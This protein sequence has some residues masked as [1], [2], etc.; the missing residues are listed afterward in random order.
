MDTVGKLFRSRDIYDLPKTDALFASAMRETCSFCYRNCD[1]YKRILDRKGFAPEMIDS[2]EDLSD[3]PFIPTLYFKHHHLKSVPDRK[4]FISATSSG[5]SGTMSNIVFDL[6]SLLTGAWMVLNVGRYHK[7]WSVVPVNYIIFGYQPSKTNRTAISKTA[8]GFTFFAPAISRTF[9][10]EMT[11]SGY[12]LNWDRVL[13]AMEKAAHSKFP[14]RT[15]GFP[16]YT[17]FL[18]KDMKAK[19]IRYKM[20]KGSMITMGGGWKQFYTE[21]PDK[22]EFYR[23]VKEVLD[24]DED[25]VV[26]FF[27]AV[28]HPILYTDCR[29]HHFHIPVYSRI[30]IRD[31][32]TM[33]PIGN[34]RIGLVNLMSPMVRSTPVL[35]IMTDDLGI[36]HDEPCPCGASSP[37]L[38]II[39]RVGV[40]DI[41]TCAAG[42]DEYLR[43]GS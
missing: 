40:S 32:D 20:P 11:P 39:G 19:G 26:E 7:L 8:Y 42:G 27:G 13:K 3:L 41:V 28:E 33:K 4:V 29:C 12:K 43:N 5:T 38:E 14:M 6:R 15:I 1:D 16:A 31:P 18:L 35:S 25:H 22:Q 34:G 36:I 17:Y 21:Q 9:A 2:I 23:L 37:W 30:L 10:L 24:I